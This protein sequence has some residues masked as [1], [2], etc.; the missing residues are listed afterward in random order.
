M[1][2]PM[3]LQ[4][5]NTLAQLVVNVHSVCPL[6]VCPAGLRLRDA[7]LD[8]LVM[9]IEFRDMMRVVGIEDGTRSSLSQKKHVHAPRV[10]LVMFVVTPTE[11]NEL[12]AFHRPRQ[13]KLA[14]RGLSLQIRLQELCGVPLF[15]ILDDR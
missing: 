4:A 14:A 15:P 12:D 13:H 1:S 6:V 10:L 7:S 3:F 11:G 8:C 9:L 2:V 5:E